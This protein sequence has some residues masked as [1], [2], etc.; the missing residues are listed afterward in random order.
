MAVDVSVVKHWDD[1]TAMVKPTGS[2]WGHRDNGRMF[3]WSHILACGHP[4][5]HIVWDVGTH[6][7]MQTGIQLLLG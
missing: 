2:I 6:G 1:D 5:A 7:I 4:F 3:L